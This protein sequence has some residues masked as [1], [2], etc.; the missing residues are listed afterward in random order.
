MM[1]RFSDLLEKEHELIS[2]E[3]IQELLSNGM[4]LRIIVHGSANA[5]DVLIYPQSIVTKYRIDFPSYASYSVSFEDFTTWN[6]TERYTGFSFRTY[7]KSNYIE[8]LQ[9]TGHLPNEYRGKTCTHYAL[10][11]IE[12]LVDILSYEEPKITVGQVGTKQT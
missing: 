9:K 12:H 1:T 8:Y 6:N 10:S 5:T 2:Y 7:S 11:C 3:S 4:S